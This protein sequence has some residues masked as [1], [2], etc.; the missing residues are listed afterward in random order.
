MEIILFDLDAAYVPVG[1]D[2]ILLRH[3]RLCCQYDQHK[4]IRSSSKWVHVH[5][6]VLQSMLQYYYRTLYLDSNAWLCYIYQ[7]DH[8]LHHYPAD[9]V[10]NVGTTW[11]I[12]YCRRGRHHEDLP[13]L[14]VTTIVIGDWTSL[15]QSIKNK[16]ERV[17]TR[18]PLKVTMQSISVLCT[19]VLPI[20]AVP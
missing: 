14:A 2:P 11:S 3:H 16:I 17:V 9:I 4:T 13:L 15:I 6:D 10:W 18:L 12:V 7:F 8:H 5:V 20:I 1:I 19:G